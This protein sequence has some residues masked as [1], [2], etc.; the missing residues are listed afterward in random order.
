MTFGN[1]LQ[2]L[3]KENN[4]SQESL[5][6]QIHVSR[7]AI[8][9][10]EQGTAVPDTDNIVMLS[11]YFQVPVEYLLFDEYD[12]PDEIRNGQSN[13]ETTSHTGNIRYLFKT[14]GLILLIIGVALDITSVI[15]AYIMQDVKMS[16]F[17]S[18]YTN[19]LF[20]LRELPLLLIVLIGAALIIT[21]I[22]LLVR[23]HQKQNE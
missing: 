18:A 12:Y 15:L 10:W 23:N 22:V 9:K 3:R 21:G 11:K 16:V 6:G 1:K 14:K 5:A 13:T 20:Y 4:M 17:G 19:A 8:S 7:Q 2:K